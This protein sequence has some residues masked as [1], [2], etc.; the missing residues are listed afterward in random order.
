MLRMRARSTPDTCRRG[1]HV[2]LTTSLRLQTPTRRDV[3]IMCAAA[4]D[5]EAQRW[6]G[7][8]NRALVPERDRDRL[9]AMEPGQGLGA[10]GYLD[11][12]LCAVDRASGLVAGGA[13]LDASSLEAGGWLAPAFRGRG[14]GKELFGAVAQ[15]G[16]LHLGMAKVAAG[17]DPANAACVAALLAAGFEPGQGPP[18]HRLQGGRTVAARWF[19]HDTEEPS[20]CR[21]DGRGRS[22]ASASPR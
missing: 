3:A 18:V 8:P 4:S 11:L 1:H 20:R 15:L 13:A 12:W 6:L 2:V 9:L 17:T 5:P 19:R 10:F 16:H 22:R 14:L 21:G 7:W